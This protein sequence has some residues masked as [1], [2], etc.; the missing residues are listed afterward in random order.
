M[1]LFCLMG[2]W[3]WM[4]PVAGKLTWNEHNRNCT[5]RS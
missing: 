1:K 4:V 3:Y 2:Y 5:G